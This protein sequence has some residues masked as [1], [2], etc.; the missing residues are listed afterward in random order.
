[1]TVYTLQRVPQN[2]LSNHLLPEVCGGLAAKQIAVTL[3]NVAKQRT[4]MGITPQEI[5]IW[6]YLP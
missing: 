4:S 2:I 6:S 5:S 1:M 3:Q